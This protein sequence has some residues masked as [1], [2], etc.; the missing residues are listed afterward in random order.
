MNS[1][2]RER[3]SY[4]QRREITLSTRQ[5][6]EAAIDT[7]IQILDE[8]QGDVYLEDAHDVEIDSDFEPLLGAPELAIEFEA[9]QEDWA[10]GSNCPRLNESEPDA[11]DEDWVQRAFAQQ[12][13]RLVG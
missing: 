11:D 12:R 1:M 9:S 3:E 13:V 5:R 2:V 6:I 8:L 4:V 7:L 10:K